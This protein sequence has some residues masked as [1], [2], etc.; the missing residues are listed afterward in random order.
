MGQSRRMSLVVS[1]TN[2][3]VGF[4]LAVLT[5][6]LHRPSF[7]QRGYDARWTKARATF[8]GQHPWCVMC[9]RAGQ[10]LR[11]TVVDHIVPH[12]GD[13]KLFWDE[14]NWRPLC[15]PHHDR[16]KQR[17]E[18]GS[19]REDVRAMFPLPSLGCAT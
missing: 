14:A 8:L 6:S 12:R 7:Q 10:H 16:E 13:P 15:K 2:V 17:A 4:V 3:F 19:A 11:A 5:N 1:V 9:M 18:R